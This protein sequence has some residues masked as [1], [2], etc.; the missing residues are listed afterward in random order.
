MTGIIAAAAAALALCLAATPGRAAGPVALFDEGHGQAFLPGRD[1]A[2][3][4]SGLAKL[5]REAGLEVRPGRGRLDAQALQGVGALIISGPFAPLAPDEVE[6]VRA[7][8]AG[9]GRLALMLHIPQPLQGLL[10]RL[11]IQYSRGPVHEAAGIIG[12]RD[13]NFA[14]TRF[15]PHAVT[16][17]LGSLSVFGCWALKNFSPQASEIAGTGAT[18]WLDSDGNGRL[19]PGEPVGEHAVVV[20]GTLGDGAYVVYGDDAVFQNRFLEEYN[21]DPGRRLARWL[22]AGPAPARSPR[23]S[24]T[25]L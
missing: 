11:G 25:K 9:G 7:F 12:G 10:E 13:S 14:V 2:L 17:R 24:G 19:S 4:L 23:P 22:A 1:G 5:L 16:D 21:R 6:A 8:V 20:A 15:R 18:A 3:D